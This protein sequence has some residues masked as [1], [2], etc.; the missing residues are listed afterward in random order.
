[1][2]EKKDKKTAVPETEDVAAETVTEDVEGKG[3]KEDK[4]SD[5]KLKAEIEL[6]R[7]E[8]EDARAAAE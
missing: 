6:L 2:A 5:K 8:L 4:K 3:K 1:M 7:G